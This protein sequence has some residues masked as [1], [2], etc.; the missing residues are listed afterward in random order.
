MKRITL[1]SI[2]LITALISHATYYLVGTQPMGY[3]LVPDKGRVMSVHP[4]GTYTIKCQAAKGVNRFVFADSLAEPDDWETF[5]ES[6][7]IGPVESVGVKKGEWTSTQKA[8][9]KKNNTAYL[10]SGSGEDHY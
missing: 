3:G 10:L 5:N 4:D 9:G 7:R 2:L 6:M 8:A 1:L